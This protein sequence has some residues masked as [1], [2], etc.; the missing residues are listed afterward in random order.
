[1]INPLPYIARY[2][3]C[4]LNVFTEVN[5]DNPNITFD[6]ETDLVVYAS[7]IAKSSIYSSRKESHGL[8]VCETKS[9]EGTTH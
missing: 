2:R 1:M 7:G 4:A 6:E 3:Q 5:E 9:L 8:R